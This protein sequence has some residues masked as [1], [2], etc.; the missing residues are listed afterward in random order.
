MS[1]RST[2]SCAQAV[3]FDVGLRRTRGE[4]LDERGDRLRGRSA[5]S[6]EPPG[7]ACRARCAASREATASAA[8]PVAGSDLGHDDLAT[9]Q[10]LVGLA[11]PGQLGGVEVGG[12]LRDEGAV[13]RAAGGSAAVVGPP[14]AVTDQDR[15]DT[16]RL[17]LVER[18]GD[19][20]RPYGCRG[21]SR[22]SPR[23]TSVGAPGRTPR[24]PAPP[25]SGCAPG[26]QPSPVGWHGAS[27]WVAGHARSPRARRRGRRGESAR[28][29]CA[30][31]G[32]APEPD[33][34]QGLDRPEADE[35]REAGDDRARPA[36]PDAGAR[37]T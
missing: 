8:G 13:A 5:G 2:S 6:R 12:C 35:L 15:V 34:H 16:C 21:R 17:G 20:R 33:E 32:P 19:D 29:P 25:R 26:P 14:A 24:R 36:Q 9:R 28:S 4:P 11:R 30:S 18:L 22:D 23:R 31:L 3:G 10:D 37:L 27:P 1:R 7:G